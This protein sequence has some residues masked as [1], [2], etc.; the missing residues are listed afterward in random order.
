MFK[1]RSSDH[2]TIQASKELQD[3]QLK[4]EV[5][6]QGG[7]QATKWCKSDAN[8]PFQ[9]IWSTSEAALDSD[10][11]SWSN[12]GKNQ[13]SSSTRSG[14]QTEKERCAHSSNSGIRR[15][16]YHNADPCDHFL[17]VLGRPYQ[18]LHPAL[19]PAGPAFLQDS[20]MMMGIFV[21]ALH[22]SSLNTQ[23]TATAPGFFFGSKPA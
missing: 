23:R 12:W 4:K 17:H 3:L 11:Q 21:P 18:P 7:P 8:S 19:A 14:W 9:S 15:G 20:Y 2:C 10:I 1:H 16:E 22:E 6:G 13:T 5:P